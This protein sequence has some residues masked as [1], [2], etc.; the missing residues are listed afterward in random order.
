M[1]LQLMSGV[2]DGWKEVK[3]V[4]IRST[5]PHLKLSQQPGHTMLDQVKE[6]LY[7]H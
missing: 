5:S 4:G 6:L 2:L 1:R 7:L 3:W